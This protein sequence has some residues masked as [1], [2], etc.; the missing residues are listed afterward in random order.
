M[1]STDAPTHEQARAEQP[2]PVTPPRSGRVRA[3]MIV[4]PY[5]SGMTAR[6][7]R[8]I[9]LA[10]RERMDLE[11]HRTERSGHAP[12]I[13]QDLMASGNGPDV[14]ISC[15]GDGTA[16]EVLN[17]M[18]LGTDTADARPAFAII[19]GG[20][21]NVLARSLGFPNH[22]VRATSRLADAIVERRHR[23][24]NLATVDERLF[25]FA[26]GVGLD[27]EVVK[28]ME[29]RR[30]G[31]RPSDSAHLASIIGI[32]A[33][34]RFALEER[35]TV[36]VDDTGEELRA[37]LLLVGNTTPM[38]YIG[39]LPLH[40]MPDCSLET[41]LDLLAPKRANALFA[42]RN[43][44]QAMG[45]GR[46]KQ[47]LVHPDKSQLRHDVS[48]ITVTCD[49]PQPVQVDGEYI[50]D[51]TDIRFGQLRRAVNLVS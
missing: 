26:A 45:M 15:G 3:A 49:D 7:E 37:A 34:S 51:R 39:R 11:V 29:A 46:S 28:R 12:L 16:N 22:P 44:A 17:G 14:I 25:M 50:G 48:A 21:T 18:S 40:F 35:M 41:G 43:A 38:T 24:I 2:R 47:R 10:L 4:N 6:R 32:Y 1:T 33:Q 42:M 8:S 13:A 20:G 19:P 5:S 30:S 9:V 27:A 36:R 31:R 23:A